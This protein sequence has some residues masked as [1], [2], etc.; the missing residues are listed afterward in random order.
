MENV[1]QQKHVALQV[2]TESKTKLTTHQ[3]VAEAD[4]KKNDQEYGDH[5]GKF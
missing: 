1:F 5:Q 3:E 2:T 4:N